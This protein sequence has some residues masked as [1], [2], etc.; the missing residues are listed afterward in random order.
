MEVLFSLSAQTLMNSSLLCWELA[1]IL[2]FHQGYTSGFEWIH[3]ERKQ[4]PAFPHF[5][6]LEP[7]GSGGNTE[8]RDRVWCSS[9]IISFCSLSPQLTM[10]P[11]PGLWLRKSW[12][13]EAR[14][15]DQRHDRGL[16]VVKTCDWVRGKLSE[17]SAVSLPS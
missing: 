12:Y 10:P 15:W 17:A 16:P 8:Y 9:S 6:S 13:L 3:A 4:S 7:R 14:P 5:K 11:F 2:L 1:L